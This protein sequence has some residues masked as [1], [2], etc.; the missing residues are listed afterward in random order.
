MKYLVLLLLNVIAAPSH[1]AGPAAGCDPQGA[2]EYVCGQRRA[3]D[4]IRIPGTDWV[5][6]SWLSGGVV[7]ISTRDRSTTVLYPD[8]QAVERHDKATY[9]DCP[10]PPDD[11]QK[12]RFSTAGIALR[13]GKNGVHT[14][15]AVHYGW[16]RGVD[17]FELDARGARPVATWVG[18][19]TAPKG[20]GVDGLVPLENGGFMITN[21]V[22]TGVDFKAELARMKTGEVNGQL[23][24]WYP[25]SGWAKVPGSESSGPNGIELSPDGKWIYFNAWGAMQFVRLSRG[26]AVS[27]RDIVQLDFRADN[28]RWGPDGNLILAGQ[29][30]DENG[31]RVVRLD[32]GTLKV[33]EL[34]TLPNSPSFGF[35]TGAIQVGNT[36]WIGSAVS[37]RIAIVPLPK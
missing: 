30:A 10:G 36:L 34:V 15:Y 3:E 23:W 22:N 35:G 25:S 18:C 9:G 6:G 29:A 32:P 21:W 13:T 2:T 31:T 19:V 12:G 14:F 16:E 5:L 24:S 20:V 1:A 7:A 26:L 28:I 4:L 27:K 8:P 17:V 33:T 37:D 11:T